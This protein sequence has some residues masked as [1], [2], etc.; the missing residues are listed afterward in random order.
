MIGVGRAGEIE[1][2]TNS[3]TTE[4][5]AVALMWAARVSQ[6]WPALV[7]LPRIFGFVGLACAFVVAW[8]FVS[9][10]SCCSCRSVTLKFQAD[11]TTETMKPSLFC[12]LL[13]STLLLDLLLLTNVS[14]CL[15]TKQNS[16]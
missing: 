13:L 4:F 7:G 14:G 10:R 6:V 9:W 12:V 3:L 11:T 2:L 1:A 15:S 16:A 5:P 8:L